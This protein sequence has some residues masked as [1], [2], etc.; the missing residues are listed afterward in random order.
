MTFFFSCQS[1]TVGEELYALLKTLFRNWFLDTE[2]P[3]ENLKRS[4]SLSAVRYLDSS[5]K[6]L[7]ATDLVMPWS[8]KSWKNIWPT[9]LQRRSVHSSW[10]RTLEQI[11]AV[12]AFTVAKKPKIKSNQNHISWLMDYHGLK[13]LFHWKSFL[14]I[15]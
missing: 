8:H 1:S 6:R 11:R 9:S 5:V 3:R 14:S 15:Y 10:D 12:L 13:A 2:I 4:K 7:F